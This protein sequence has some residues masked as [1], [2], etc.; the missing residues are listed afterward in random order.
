MTNLQKL[1]AGAA[2]VILAVVLFGRETA[3]GWVEAAWL[4]FTAG[5][6]I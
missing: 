3:A 2:A 4:F 1:L 5:G 6:G